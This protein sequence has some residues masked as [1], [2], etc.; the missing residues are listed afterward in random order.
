MNFYIS[1]MFLTPNQAYQD[2]YELLLNW[3]VVV[4]LGLPKF[5]GNVMVTV[6]HRMHAV[7]PD[8]YGK[9]PQIREITTLLY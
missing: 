7:P 8:L 1:K 6:L 4:Y 3:N 5:L 2:K 9:I